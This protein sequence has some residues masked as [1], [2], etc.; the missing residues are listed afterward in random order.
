MRHPLIAVEPQLQMRIIA[1]NPIVYGLLSTLNGPA[2]S[3]VAVNGPAT[4]SGSRHES[5]QVPPHP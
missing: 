4:F 1:H 2:T 5:E 3:I